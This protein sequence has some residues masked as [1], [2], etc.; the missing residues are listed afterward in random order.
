MSCLLLH[1][2]SL[3][4][5]A[6][7]VGTGFTCVNG[8]DLAVVPQEQCGFNSTYDYT[9]EFNSSIIANTNFNVSYG[10]GEFVIGDFGFENVTLANLT[11]RQ[12][13]AVASEAYWFGTG[14]DSGL[15]GLAY[16]LITSEYPGDDPS[17][18]TPTNSIQYD[19]IM[20]TMF[21][22]HP[23][24]EPIFSLSLQ[25]SPS[26]NSIVSFGGYIALGGL[27]P[28]KNTSSF[29]TTPLVVWQAP[30]QTH[31]DWNTP[32]VF[33]SIDVQGVQYQ[34]ESGAAANTNQNFTAFVDSG[35]TLRMSRSYNYC[36]EPRKN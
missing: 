8:T 27:P 29:V 16:P 24:I 18:D 33:Y 31:P 9:S 11:V 21:K 30:L 15:M 28:V 17:L 34:D 32:K 19:P 25:R 20:T 1:E 10:D 2:R 5:Y 6:G 22:Q 3:L 14:Y 13:V 12:Q 23:E 7:V 36:S 4:L 26:I 35:T